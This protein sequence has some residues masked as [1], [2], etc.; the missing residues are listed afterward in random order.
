MRSDKLVP[1]TLLVIIGIV[2]LLNNFGVIDFSWWTFFSLWPI[3]LI[4][5][6]VNLV[7]AH[8]R[9]AW[10]IILKMAVLVGGM[11]ILIVSGLNHHDRGWPAWVFRFDRN[12]NNNDNNRDDD[13]IDTANGERAVVKVDGNSIYRQAYKPGLQTAKLNITGGA[14]TYSLKGVTNDLFV[15]TTKEYNNHYSL[16]TH[17]DSTHA[18]IDFDMNMHK[19]SSWH[20]DNKRENRAD[21]EL[22]SNPEWDIDL[23]SGASKA[24]FD[25]SPFKVKNL[26]IQGGASSYTVKLGQPLAKTSVDISTGMASVTL[27][28]PKSAACHVTVDTGLSSKNLE[29]FNKR[30]DDS[31]ETPGF[32]KATNKIEVSFEAG[33]SNLKV[34][35]Y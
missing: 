13:D 3:L 6:G 17:T 26:T 20:F 21:I 12:Y 2:F 15:A 35:R 8:N 9:S 25:L 19:H 16:K 31:Y 28:I 14:T 5:G 30:D 33:M 1:G 29:G 18:E 11:A 22:N 34:I 27:Y 4:I 10:A 7:F 24:D 32:D 23:E